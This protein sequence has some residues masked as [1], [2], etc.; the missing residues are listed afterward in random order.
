MSET[1]GVLQ[2][3]VGRNG[4]RQDPFEQHFSC[5]AHQHNVKVY[6]S[7]EKLQLQD[8]HKDQSLQGLYDE[9]KS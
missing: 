2:T 5:R 3:G 4:K 9:M 7:M 6:E 1:I 8:L